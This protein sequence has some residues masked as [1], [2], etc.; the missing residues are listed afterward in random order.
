[1]FAVLRRV[2]IVMF[3]GWGKLDVE[4]GDDGMFQPFGQ[5]GM[6]DVIAS[7]TECGLATLTLNQN[8]KNYQMVYIII[9]LSSQH[10]SI[11]T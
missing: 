1:M 3:G 9:L 10:A 7:M 8:L 11:M 5:P 6:V 2:D 4:F